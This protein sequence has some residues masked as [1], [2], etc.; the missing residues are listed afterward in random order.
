MRVCDASALVRLPPETR[1]SLV[2]TLTKKLCSLKNLHDSC[3]RAFWTSIT[4][5]AIVCIA[6]FFALPSL[7]YAAYLRRAG[8]ATR[9]FLAGFLTL[10]EAE[11]LTGVPD[12]GPPAKHSRRNMVFLSWLALFE[13]FAW[14]AVGSYRAVAL[15][16]SQ[17]ASGVWEVA[18]PLLIACTWFYAMLRPIFRQ[19]TT[20]PFD[21]FILFV[22]YLLSTLLSLG[23]VLY[24]RCSFNSPWPPG[25]VQFASFLDLI[26]MATSIYV[27]ISMPLEI[28][29]TSVADNVGVTLTPEDYSTLWGYV[30][31]ADF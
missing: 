28:P 5:A 20:P 23:V 17:K 7:C 12:D 6:V 11:Q 26:V 27:V 21:L 15:E 4:P 29:N 14:L 22:S 3:V 30:I 16:Y 13:T 19:T 8:G 2:E 24:D 9:S 18:A 10:K 31:P 25:F 1:Q